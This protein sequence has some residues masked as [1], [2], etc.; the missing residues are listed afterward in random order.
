MLDPMTD[1]VALALITAASTVL[2]AIVSACAGRIVR[3]PIP[4]AAAPPAASQSST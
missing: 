3:G 2:L 4:A 1:P